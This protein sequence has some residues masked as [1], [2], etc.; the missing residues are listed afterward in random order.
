MSIAYYCP[1]FFFSQIMIIYDF[2]EN[3][4]DFFRF[5]IILSNF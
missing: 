3:I 2:I 1:D 5:R 4:T